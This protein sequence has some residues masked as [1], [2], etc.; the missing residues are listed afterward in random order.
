MSCYVN[1]EN[2]LIHG[3]EHIHSL[4]NMQYRMK[5]V[6][7]LLVFGLFAVSVGESVYFITKK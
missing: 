7:G 5:S 4:S 6:V 1:D 2:I 3:L